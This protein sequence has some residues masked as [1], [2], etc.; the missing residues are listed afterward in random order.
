MSNFLSKPNQMPCVATRMKA[1]VILLDVAKQHCV[2]PCMIVA[3]VRDPKADV[4]RKQVQARM[5]SE[6]GMTRCSIASAFLRH[7]RRVRAAIIGV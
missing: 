7:P 5:F 3:H 4:A 2:A 1:R 6:T